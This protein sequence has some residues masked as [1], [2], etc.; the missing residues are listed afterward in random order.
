[1]LDRHPLV[2]TL[3]RTQR[4]VVVLIC[5]GKTNREIAQLRN[6]GE[7]TI[8]NMLTK[9]IFPAFGVSSRSA[10]VGTCLRELRA[11]TDNH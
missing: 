2:A 4:E 3:P 1:M 11:A 9:N 10:L 5:M 7:Q 8:K 6:V